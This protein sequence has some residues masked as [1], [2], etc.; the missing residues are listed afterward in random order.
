MV[1]I[2]LGSFPALLRREKKGSPGG[3]YR[4]RFWYVYISWPLGTETKPQPG[5]DT[6]IL[7]LRMRNYLN[8]AYP[9]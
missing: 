7:D 6:S 2:W 9:P 5:T 8:L 1:D 3:E 4:T